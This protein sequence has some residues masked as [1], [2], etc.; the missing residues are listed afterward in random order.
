MKQQDWKDKIIKMID[1]QVP[2]R[3]THKP[4]VKIVRGVR[5]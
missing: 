1:I 5:G 2:K 3:K 4:K